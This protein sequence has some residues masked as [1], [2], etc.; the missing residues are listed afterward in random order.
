MNREYHKWRSPTL[1]R[2]MELLVF[3]HAG[4][5]LLV[6][7]TRKQR[8]FEYEDCGMIHAL[9][10]SIESG[11]LQV[12]CVDGID[13]ESLYCFDIIP[14]QR[15][16][17]HLQFE[18]YILSE[19]LPFSE[20]LNPHTPLI[21]HG[22]SFG[23]YHAVTIA[24]RN[25]EHFQRVVAFSGR[26]D[27]TL[28]TGE[29]HSLFHGYSGRELAYI[30]PSHFL[31]TVRNE[32]LLR[33]MRRIDFTMVVGEDDPFCE[34]NASLCRTFTSQRIPHTLHLWCGVSHK[35]CYWRQMVRIY[36]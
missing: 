27:L 24:L 26:Y 8:F 1:G 34:N 2:D 22:C 29:Y 25:P 9:R 14:E 7:P 6:F 23:A 13:H 30:M 11:K 20:K 32:K 10:H 5:R 18:R 15:I 28:H 31:P 19:V 33:K 3:G 17:R 21:A 4:M 12:V 36:L 35:F 16:E